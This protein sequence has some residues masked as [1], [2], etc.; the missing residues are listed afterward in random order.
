MY[1]GKIGDKLT[2]DFPLW[3]E[4]LH[5]F[6]LASVRSKVSVD[7]NQGQA[8]RRVSGMTEPGKNQAGV[9][10]KIE[11]KGKTAKRTK[12]GAEISVISRILRHRSR[13]VLATNNIFVEKRE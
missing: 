10:R 8:I 7:R 3:N 9:R 1:T 6:L 12:C 2:L 5:Y 11:G 4:E 13:S